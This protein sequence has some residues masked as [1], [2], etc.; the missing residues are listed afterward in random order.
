MKEHEITACPKCGMPLERTVSNEHYWMCY[1]CI[2]G[3]TWEEL[4][5]VMKYKQLLK[6]I[7]Q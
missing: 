5:G 4:L 3:W 2:K 7:E 6:E 1:I